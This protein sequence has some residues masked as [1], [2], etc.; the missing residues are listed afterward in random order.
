MAKQLYL[1]LLLFASVSF[2]DVS[3]RVDSDG[4]YAVSID[5][6]QWFTSGPTW[7]QTNGTTFSSHNNTLRLQGIQNTSGSDALGR[8]TATELQ[9]AAN[10]V[11]IKTTIRT[12]ETENI[13][14]FDQ[15]FP[16][17]LTNTGYGSQDDTITAFPNFVVPEKPDGRGY[18]GY[19]NDMVG[20]VRGGDWAVNKEFPG[21]L[22]GGPV[23][24]FD[25]ALSVVAVASP[26]SNFMAASHALIDGSLAFGI[27]GSVTSVPSGYSLQTILQFGRGPSRGIRS[28]MMQWGSSLLKFYNKA[29]EPS[30]E[31]DITLKYLG[32][33]TDNGAYYY[34]KT[35]PGKNYEDTLVD[36]QKYAQSVGI[37]YRYILL[38][39]WWYYKGK[40]NGVSNWTAMPEIFP[41]NLTGFYERTGWP[42]QAHNRYWAPD[43]TYAKKN[44]GPWDFIVEDTLSLP[45]SQAFWDFLIEDSKKWGLA[46]YEQ[47]WLYNEIEGLNHLLESATLGRDWLMQMGTAAA[48]YNVAIQYCMAWPRHILQS[49]ELPAVTNARASGD[50]MQARSSQWQIGV[51]S[52]FA[53]AV[54]LAPSKDN[55]WSRA[56]QPGNPYNSHEPYS[57]LQSAVSSFS[58][59]PVAPS[60]MINGSDPSLILRACMPDGT[61]LRPSQ[62]ATAID[63]QFLNYAFP[64]LGLVGEVWHGHSTVGGL[65]WDH[66]LVAQLAQAVSLRPAD[67][68][69]NP[70]RWAAPV[71]QVR[72]N[73]T[74]PPKL[75]S[76]AEPIQAEACNPFG[77]QVYYLAPVLP[78]GWALHGETEKWVR[79]SPV[80]F[81]N[82]AATANGADA[83]LVGVTG[84]TVVVEFSSP[85]AEVVAV[86]CRFSTAG[87]MTASVPQRTCA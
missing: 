72:Y 18:V 32:Y 50:Y 76:A 86:T 5:N 7:V 51:S 35:E 24:V 2:A 58:G 8:F 26:F 68:D 47:D 79:V 66:V 31:Y 41:H 74:A 28:A 67:L 71:R 60:D 20:N 15:S 84:E 1:L 53:I 61:L 83:R 6:Q 16:S 23:I 48:K 13:V 85:A 77:F 56:Q 39:S 14:I 9:W 42:V 21:G 11:V 80:R 73:S 65:T 62:A 12:Y 36:V 46:V 29:S 75:F 69:S 59:G 17:G 81:V 27:M 45:D 33:S 40:G 43:S 57:P 10:L 70:A 30:P 55:Y 54:G 38:D 19:H 44:G 78:N 34:Y 37:P 3:V 22:D 49:L 82:F 64:N 4:S 63:A 25:K 52:L 87:I